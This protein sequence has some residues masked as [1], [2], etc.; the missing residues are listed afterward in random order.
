[1]LCL[2]GFLLP[3]ALVMVVP[4]G[5]RGGGRGRGGGQ[6]KAKAKAK[7][8]APK[9]K[10]S[11]KKAPRNGGESRA[12]VKVKKEP[13][14]ASEPAKDPDTK[15]KLSN[16]VTQ[17]KTA[18]SKLA[19]VVA[20]ELSVSPEE[21]ETLKSKAAFYQEYASLPRSATSSRMEMLAS[22]ESDR[23]GRAWATKE[24]VLETETA[25]SSGKVGGAISRLGLSRSK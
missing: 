9:A 13:G 1:M 23:A 8:K 19:K 7:G 10:P 2:L 11:P 17:G 15:G 3:L 21:L 18:A 25:A 16:L 4:R 20:G 24:K 14:T 5:G 12:L 6:P 22:W